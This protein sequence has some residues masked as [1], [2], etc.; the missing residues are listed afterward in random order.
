MKADRQ[1]RRRAA[2]AAA[3]VLAILATAAALIS[4]SSVGAPALSEAAIRDAIRGG[5]A[6]GVIGGAWGAPVEFRFNGRIVPRRRVPRWSAA[7]ANRYTFERR[8]GPD[9]TYVE[10]PFLRALAGDVL[11]GWPE[12]ARLL[13]RSRFPLFVENLRARQNLRAG[14][15]PPGSGDPAHNPYAS[16]IGFQIESDW[17]G[18]VAPGQPGVAID[19]AWRAGHVIGYG[20]GV[21]GGVMVAAM[22]AAAFGA[23]GVGQIVE[24][25][26]RA[27]PRGSAYRSMI[28]DVLRWH[29]LRPRN[30]KWAWRRLERRWNAHRASVKRDPRYV[31]HEFNIDQKLNGGYILL[32]LLYGGG[33]FAR[34]IRISMRAGQDADCNPSNAASILGTWLGYRGIPRR[35]TRGLAWKRPIVGTAFTLRRAVRTTV[36]VARAVTAA[37]GGSVDGSRWTLPETNA[38]APIAERWPQRGNRRPSLSAGA[39]VTGLTASFDAG[40]ADAD[41]IRGFWWS[42]GDLSDG[43]GP[44]PVHTYRRPGTYRATVWVADARGRTRARVVRVTV[45]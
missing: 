44:D 12:W 40:A 20:D 36:A 17:A 14:I 24:A 23:G 6:G 29:R 41:G 13:R 30:W 15:A 26:R 28:E 11:A 21:Y 4:A 42:F 33:H 22:H 1:R 38:L 35:F 5:W 10:I 31:H 34:T 7:R 39:S 25:G 19:L 18:L 32:G 9:E 8:T 2:V 27:V 45:R 43:V 3:A 37:G 16:D